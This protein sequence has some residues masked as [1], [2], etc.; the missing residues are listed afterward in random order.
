MSLDLLVAAIEGPEKQ[1]EEKRKEKQRRKR[2]GGWVG[3]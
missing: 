2:V 1:E 3:E